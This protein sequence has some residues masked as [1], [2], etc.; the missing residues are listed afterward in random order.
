MSPASVS[1]SKLL[2]SSFDAVSG[3][4]M[5]GEEEGCDRGSIGAEGWY[6]LYTANGAGARRGIASSLRIGA[7]LPTV[8]LA[9]SVLV[10]IHADCVRRFAGLAGLQYCDESDDDA[11]LCA[12]G[13]LSGES[14][15]V[16]SLYQL[17]CTG[18]C[19]ALLVFIAA[20]MS[21]E[22]SATMLAPV[23][24]SKT[25]CCMVGGAGPVSC[26]DLG[27]WVDCWGE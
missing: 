21:A 22:S 14:R 5:E 10:L 23:S 4:E 17:R 11:R 24:S 26:T 13:V 8:K 15:N 20:L 25:G 7:I 27:C 1:V 12:S 3:G 6:A 2:G 9:G 19:P 18:V 16:G